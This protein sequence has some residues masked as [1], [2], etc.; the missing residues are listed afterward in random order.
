MILLSRANTSL[1]NV[2]NYTNSICLKV[3]EYFSSLVS[4]RAPLLC[5]ISSNFISFFHTNR[6]N[7]YTLYQPHYM[8]VHVGVILRMPSLTTAWASLE[9]VLEVQGNALGEPELWSILC[10]CAETL[11]DIIF[12]GEYQRELLIYF[13]YKHM[14]MCLFILRWRA[15]AFNQAQWT[16]DVHSQQ[17]WFLFIL[18]IWNF[19]SRSTILYGIGHIFCVNCF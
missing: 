5:L 17:F 6:Y 14:I 8:F 12:R 7:S 16:V 9:D 2:I 13:A 1:T 3:E 4:W 15:Q 18:N 11:Q 10:Q 19:F